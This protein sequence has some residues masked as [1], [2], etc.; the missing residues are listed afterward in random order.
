MGSAAKGLRST[1]DAP[2]LFGADETGFKP[3]GRARLVALARMA[4]RERV[5]RGTKKDENRRMMRQLRA[6]GDD[7]GRRFGLM[8]SDAAAAA[9]ADALAALSV[10]PVALSILEA[11]GRPL[12]NRALLGGYEPLYLDHRLGLQAVQ[13]VQPVFVFEHGLEQ[14]VPI[15]QHQKADR[16]QAAQAMDD[17]GDGS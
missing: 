1:T 5:P 17:E 16:S 13:W 12:Y 2:R 9:D 3:V 6:W 10:D 4:K 14:A 7:L 8:V 11:P 15:A